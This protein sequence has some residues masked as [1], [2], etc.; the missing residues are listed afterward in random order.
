MSDT[1]QHHTQNLRWSSINAEIEWDSQSFSPVSCALLKAPQD[2]FGPLG[3]QG[4]SL[5]HIELHSKQIFQIPFCRASF[6]PLVPQSIH[7]PRH[8][9][10]YCPKYRIQYWLL[11]SFMCIYPLF[12]LSISFSKT[13]LLS[14]ESVTPP[15]SLSSAN[16]VRPVSCV[17]V[18]NKNI[19]ENFLSNWA[20]REHHLWLL[21]I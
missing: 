8:K 19:E 5:V 1:A 12:L 10:L 17:Q 4:A 2:T 16:F 15:N 20:L 3:C 9:A 11:L 13:S 7:A 14:R 18:I 21:A 6:Q